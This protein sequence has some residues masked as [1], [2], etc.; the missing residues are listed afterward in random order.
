MPAFTASAPGKII[1]FGEHAVVYGQPAIAAPV[2]QVRARA[3]VFARVTETRGAW[4]A[5][6]TDRADLSPVLVEAPDIGLCSS[7]AGLHPDHPLARAILLVF[8]ALQVVRPPACTVC[9]SSTIPLAAGMGSG[10]AVSVAVIRALSAFLG[11]PLPLE[12]VS[13][14]AFEVEKIHHGTPSGIDNSVVAFAKPVYYQRGQPLATLK[15]PV[16]FQIVIGDTGCSTPTG[17]VVGDVRRRWQVDPSNYEALFAAIGEIARQARP[18]IESGSPHKLGPLLD[19]NHALLTQLGVSSPQLET[20]VDAARR[21][22]ALGAKLSGGGRGGAMLA[23]VQEQDSR[24][25]ATALQE[26][27]ASRVIE[28][29]VGKKARGRS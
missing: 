11:H 25:V 23:L 22:G 20:L 6:Y 12:Q 15:L 3:Y 29:T 28:T 17:E 19:H 16:S 26:A 2:S 14:M 7:L 18:L 10:A 21:S 27:G 8:E 5:P 13:K 4:E 9:V 24:R 1:L